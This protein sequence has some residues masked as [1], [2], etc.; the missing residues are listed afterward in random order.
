MARKRAK[1]SSSSEPE[2][3]GDGIATE[4]QVQAQEE[5]E[6]PA[7]AVDDGDAAATAVSESDRAFY[8][9]AGAY[10]RDDTGVL[11]SAFTPGVH[12]S[13]VR[14]L[15]VVFVVLF[16]C[17]TSLL[18]VTRGNLHVCVFFV[19]AIL[20]SGSLQWYVESRARSVES[21]ARALA[22]ARR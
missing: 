5:H 22:A 2:S 18:V 6:E 4:Q 3:Q 21:R 13:L 11:E 7:A 10:V 1:P 15:N 17:L 9:N 14:A 16:V 20:L 19:L 12:A 8:S